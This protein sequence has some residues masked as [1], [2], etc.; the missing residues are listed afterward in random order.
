MI[1][2]D[3]RLNVILELSLPVLHVVVSAPALLHARLRNVRAHHVVHARLG[4]LEEV[5]AL[6]AAK[7]QNSERM[8]RD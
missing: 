5:A 4:P 2:I 3:S 1:K 8:G 6:A 7:I